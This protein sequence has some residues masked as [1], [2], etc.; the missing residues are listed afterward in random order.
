MFDYSKVKCLKINS[1]FFLNKFL[2]LKM[3]IKKLWRMTAGF[4]LFL[5]VNSY[6]FA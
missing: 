2:M 5:Y 6:L 1:F 4:I 3:G